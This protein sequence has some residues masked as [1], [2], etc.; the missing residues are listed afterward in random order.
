MGKGFGIAALVVLLLSLPIPVMGN[1]VSLMAMLLLCVAAYQRE[2]A[3]TIA[4]DLVAWVKMFMLSPTWHFMM[5][6]GG[7]MRGAQRWASEGNRAVGVRD[8]VLDQMMDGS[9]RAMGGLNTMALLMTVVL[10]SAPIAILIW[11]QNAA[12]GALIPTD[13]TK[14]DLSAAVL[15]KTSFFSPR[16]VPLWVGVFLTLVV[17]GLIMQAR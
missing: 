12:A 6:G 10:L 9:T 8:P 5:F 2:A 17:A 14:D 15:E 11:R 16:N 1:Y 4:V 3:W 7:Y 13:G